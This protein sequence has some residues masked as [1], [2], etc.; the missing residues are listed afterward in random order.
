M[1]LCLSLSLCLCL[2]VSLSLSPLQV[3]NVQLYVQL[4]VYL[5]SLVSLLSAACS[6]A[7]LGDSPGHMAAPVCPGCATALLFA[8][9]NL[10]CSGSCLCLA[11]GCSV[12]PLP[13]DL[14]QA[15]WGG[16]S[17]VYF[18]RN[19][20]W[21]H[22]AALCFL[23]EDRRQMSLEQSSSAVAEKHPS[24]VRF[25]CQTLTIGQTAFHLN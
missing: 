13:R 11:C 9:G 25:D 7:H 18:L 23:Q 14:G 21:C 1:C 6:L 8:M 4:Y 3:I 17:P 2:S 10:H 16:G 19:I 20:I 12:S 5:L 22:E 24:A 15:A